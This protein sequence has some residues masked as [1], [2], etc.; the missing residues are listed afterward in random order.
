MN[1]DQ[2]TYELIERYL[3]GELAGDELVRFEQAMKED[4]AL[5]AEVDLQQSV[6]QLLAEKDV[7]ALDQQLTDLRQDY[8]AETPKLLP[9]R[10]IWFAAAAVL[11]LGIASIGFFTT[12]DPIDGEELYLSYFEPYPADNAVRSQEDDPTRVSQMEEALEAYAKG[13]YDAAY[14]RFLA[15]LYIDADDLRAKFYLGITLLAQGHGEKAAETLLEVAEQTDS[16]YAD[17]ARWYYTLS[18]IRQNKRSAARKELKA[19]EKEARG[20]YQKLAIEMLDEL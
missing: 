1:H 16:I 10:K 9:F 11:V 4:A 20:K 14:Q 5:A 12:A 13:D 8:G 15:C 6:Q 19:L 2:E 7:L 18:L 3:Q 17:P